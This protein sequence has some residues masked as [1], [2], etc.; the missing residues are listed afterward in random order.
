MSYLSSELEIESSNDLVNIA[1]YLL[2]IICLAPSFVCLGLFL[3]RVA[4]VCLLSERCAKTHN[5][6]SVR[7]LCGYL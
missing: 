7:L 6:F 2:K 4:A 5:L 3:A 1:I